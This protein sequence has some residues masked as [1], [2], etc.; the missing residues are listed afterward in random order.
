M[1]NSL[2]LNKVAVIVNL[3]HLTSL[4]KLSLTEC[5]LESIEFV[6]QLVNLEYLD[7]SGNVISSMEPVRAC[8]QLNYLNLSRN[9]LWNTNELQVLQS[10]RHLVHFLIN[11]NEFTRS[12]E[13]RINAH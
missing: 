3:S 6:R 10:M 1:L 7:V 12:E 9:L 13:E 2:S 4:T 11:E 8:V 5:H